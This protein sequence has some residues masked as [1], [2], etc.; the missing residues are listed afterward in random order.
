MRQADGIVPP[1]GSIAS[2]VPG[3]V[4]SAVTATVESLG[5]QYPLAVAQVVAILGSSAKAVDWL[6]SP[7]GAL[8]INTPI[9]LLHRGDGEAVEIELGR[10]RI[11]H[12]RLRVY[13]I[14]LRSHC[15][16]AG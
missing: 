5:S 12:L 16:L 14:A 3:A 15:R 8:E 11:R 9:D 10:I 2:I 13:R 6:T 7:C 1:D 4:K